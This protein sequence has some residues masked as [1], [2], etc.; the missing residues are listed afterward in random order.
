LF[1]DIAAFNPDPAEI[2]DVLSADF[3]DKIGAVCIRDFCF[4][5]CCHLSGEPLEG[6]TGAIDSTDP[7]IWLLFAKN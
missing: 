1:I 6:E 5:G 7:V 2:A 4:S 3:G